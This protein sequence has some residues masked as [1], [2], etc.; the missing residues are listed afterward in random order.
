LRAL[1]AGVALLAASAAAV[2]LHADDP[3]PVP[4]PLPPPGA[5]RLSL[6]G[7]F[8]RGSASFTET[9]TFTEFAEEGR[10]ESRYQQDPGPGFEAGALWRFARRLGVSAAVSI[11]RRKE[12][13]SFSASL[14]HPLFFGTPRQAAGD[15]AGRAQRET[16]VHAALAV[17]GGAG[18][19]QWMAFAGPSL[20]GIRTDLVRTVEYTHAYPYDSVRVTATPFDSAS[21]RALG[22]NIGGGLAWQA[23]RHVAI[24]TQM[25]LSRAKVELAP[26]SDDRLKMDAGGA[27]FTGGVRLDF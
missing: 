26:T 2:P 4:V 12:A 24:A 1:L 15:F 8:A 10:I 5:V 19:L 27:S 20:I 21:G 7:G 23:A 17:L 16:A 25:R 11:A 3:A 13:G 14:P 9:R 18:R 22:F 6:L